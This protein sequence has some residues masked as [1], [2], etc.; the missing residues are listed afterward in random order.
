MEAKAKLSVHLTDLN[1]KSSEI[2]FSLAHVNIIFAHFEKLGAKFKLTNSENCLQSDFFITF[3]I[4]YR[5]VQLYIIILYL[6]FVDIYICFN[7]VSS[8]S[9]STL[10]F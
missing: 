10:D 2:L 9:N 5:Q 3:K 6:Y 4:K 8:V 1:V 7:V